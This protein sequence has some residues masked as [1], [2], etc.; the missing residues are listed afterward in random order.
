MQSEHLLSWVFGVLTVFEKNQ[1]NT[2]LN[3]KAMSSLLKPV[4]KNWNT[5][6]AMPTHAQTSERIPKKKGKNHS[7]VCSDIKQVC[8]KTT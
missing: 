3:V 5:N 1:E 6:T 7:E 2:A 8:R 4:S